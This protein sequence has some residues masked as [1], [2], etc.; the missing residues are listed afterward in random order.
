MT[1]P[2]RASIK[3]HTFI[4][5]FEGL[6]YTSAKTNRPVDQCF[7]IV[8]A[9]RA[10]KFLAALVWLSIFTA[11]LGSIVDAKSTAAMIS[12]QSAR[13]PK[14]MSLIQMLGAIARTFRRLPASVWCMRARAFILRESASAVCKT[15]E[16]SL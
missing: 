9:P 3:G 6:K 8:M 12:E 16:W 4:I 14:G 11:L 15:G 5:K 2:A 1:C 13:K 10:L 7:A